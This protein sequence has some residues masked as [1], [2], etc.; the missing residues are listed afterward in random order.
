MGD[1]TDNL[2]RTEFRC[3]CGE[4]GKSPGLGYCGGSFMAADY[5][6]VKTI[7]EAVDHF[8]MSTGRPVGVRITSGCRCAKHNR[9]EGGASKS[10]HPLGI[11]ADHYLYFKDTNERVGADVLADWYEAQHPNEFGVGRYESGR[12]HLD[13]RRSSARWD[14]RK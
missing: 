5:L 4:Q 14:N 12:V 3:Q 1:L 2:S 6:L 10:K 9:D 7:Q 8:S 13:S 11:A